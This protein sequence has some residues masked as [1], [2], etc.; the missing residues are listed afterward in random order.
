MKFA[1]KINSQNEDREYHVTSDL[2]F[3]HKNIIKHCPDTRLFESV[4]EMNVELV[5][6]WNSTIGVNDVVFHVGDFSFGN[7]EHTQALLAQLNG[8]IIFIYGNHDKILRKIS[9]VPSTNQFFDYLEIMFNGTK[10]CMGH[11][12]MHVWNQSGRG[13]V[14]LYGHTHGSFEAPGRTMDIGYDANGRILKLQKAVDMCEQRD[15]YTPDHH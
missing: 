11:Y 13:S 1:Q 7:E 6:H 3:F 12:P 10:V 8:T 2:H 15:I 5:N 14:M 4:D 9:K